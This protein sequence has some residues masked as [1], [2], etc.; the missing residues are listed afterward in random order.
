MNKYGLTEREK[1]IWPPKEEVDS[2]SIL[3]KCFWFAI[4]CTVLATIIHFTIEPKQ[5][6]PI[7]NVAH[8]DTKQLTDKEQEKKYCAL[9]ATQKMP[10]QGGS[11]DEIRKHCNKFL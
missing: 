3:E 9:W 5:M 2:I 8:A 4:I 1:A 6:L 7:V 10:V 11:T